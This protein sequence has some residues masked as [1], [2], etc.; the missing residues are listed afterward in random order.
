MRVP[1]Q[2]APMMAPPDTR[3]NTNQRYMFFHPALG[4]ESAS[5]EEGV[6]DRGTS[7]GSALVLDSTT[8]LLD[9]PYGDCFNLEERWIVKASFKEAEGCAGQWGCIFQIFGDVQVQKLFQPC[10]PIPHAVV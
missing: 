6:S 7:A 5:G 9:I 10:C 4:E 1:V 3:V 8:T 2:N